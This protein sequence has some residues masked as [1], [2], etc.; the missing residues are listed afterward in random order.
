MGQ[1]FSWVKSNEKQILVILDNLAKK[2]V[3]VSEAVVVMLSDLGNPEHNKKIHILET[4]ADS[5]V[6]EVFSELNKTFITPLDRE[7]MQRVA[8]KIDDTIDH[9]DG[10]SARLHSYKITTT[11]PYAL[12]MANELVKGTKEVEQMTSKLRNIKNPSSMLEHCRNTSAVEH[13][14]DDLYSTAI[15]ELFE[16]NDAIQIIKLKDIYESLEKAS[17]RCVDVADV[18]EDIVLKYT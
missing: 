12:E 1:F 7:D 11:P 14:V 16:T 8:S 18:V 4:E 17:D 2:G 5:L 10:I 13:K 6:R 15:S 9:I 3:E